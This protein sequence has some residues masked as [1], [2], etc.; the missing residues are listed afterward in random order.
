VKQAVMAAVLAERAKRPRLFAEGAYTPLIAEGP[1]A[2]DV[3]A[4]ARTLGDESVVIVALRNVAARLNDGDSLWLPPTLLRDDHIAPPSHV[5]GRRMVDRLSKRMIDLR[6]K[7]PLGDA[8]ALPIA[9][10]T[11]PE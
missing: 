5:A 11:D 2:S 3:V 1:N 8:L 7:T 10:L 6:A 9:F 4:F